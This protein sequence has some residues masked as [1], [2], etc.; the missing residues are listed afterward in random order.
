[1]DKKKI[2]IGMLICSLIIILIA[3]VGCTT[4]G[5][6]L[7]I[8]D[9]DKLKTLIK[10]EDSFI[11]YVSNKKCTICEKF[12]PVF[13][14]VIEEYKL[15]VYKIDTYTLTT[16]EFKEMNEYANIQGTPTVEFFNDGKEESTL[17]RMDGSYTK[18]MIIQSLTENEYI[19]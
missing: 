15:N 13:K 4:N 18:K 1:M 19:K 8:I 10:N 9:V 6:N 17:N 7:K 2:T 12:E 14:E 16:D 11:L 3:V 5:S